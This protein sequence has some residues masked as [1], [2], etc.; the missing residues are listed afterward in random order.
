MMKNYIKADNEKTLLVRLK[1]GDEQA[2]TILYHKYRGTLY[3][4]I[5]KMVKLKDQSADL[6]TELF[7]KVW[8]RRVYIDPE[9]SFKAFIYRIAQ[10]M[11][12]DYFRQA[13]RDRSL[14]TQLATSMVSAPDYT[15]VDDAIQYKECQSMI[16]EALSHLPKQCRQVFVMCKI[17]GKSYEEVASILSI[18]KAT[19]NNHITKANRMLR[20]F[21]EQQDYF[22]FVLISLGLLTCL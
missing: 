9:L 11:V 15:P 8:Q 22:P 16:D 17:E 10:N 20:V 2:F 7:I 5:Y 12:Y 18:S 4:S 6:L 21:I 1:Q 13:A 19:V 3:N 14:Q